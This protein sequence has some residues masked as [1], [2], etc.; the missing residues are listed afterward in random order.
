MPCRFAQ[1][2]SPAANVHT[3]PVNHK[4]ML[5]PMSFISGPLAHCAPRT[6]ADLQVSLRLQMAQVMERNP[7]RN[8]PLI[9]GPGNDDPMA[10]RTVPI[11]TPT[12]QM[13]GPPENDPM[14]IT[15]PSSSAPQ[16]AT[17]SPDRDVN[18]AADSRNNDGARGDV[19]P[20]CNTNAMTMPAPPAAAP[21]VGGPKIV[22]TAFIH[23]LYK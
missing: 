14:D 7:H 20:Q 2:L 18:G 23:K 4:P 11:L 10:P 6:H 22:Q 16:S 3:L 5:R 8:N 19:Q 9:E 1:L 13:S 15:T 12:I 21:G 17:R